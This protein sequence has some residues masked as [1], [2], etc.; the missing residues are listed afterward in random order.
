MS[1]PLSLVVLISGNGSNLQSII[2]SIEQGRVNAEIKAVISN[3]AQAYGLLRARKHGIASYLVNHR[4]FASREAFDDELQRILKPVDADFILLAGFMRILGSAAIQA[5][6]DKIL[7]IHPSLLP[8]YKGLNTYRRA[9]DSGEVEHGVS[10]HLVTAELDD[11]PV[12]MQARYPIAPGDNIEDLQQKGHKLEHR[13]YP[14][15]LCWLSEGKIEISADQIFYE[16]TVLSKP[17]EFAQV[18]GGTGKI[19]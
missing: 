19:N 4:D 10:I 11:G 6:A 15:L 2:D 18:A 16:K 12:I 7:N 1:N 3:N 8:A 14:Q 13:M 17:V 5:F 9:L